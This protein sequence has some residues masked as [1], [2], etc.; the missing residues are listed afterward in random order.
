MLGR[1][2]LASGLVL[3]VFV[4]GHFL[5]HSLG[6]VSLSAMNQG[7]YYTIAPWR[8]A[9][10]TVIF[11]SALLTHVG[12]AVWALYSR[13]TLRLKPAEYVQAGLGF[14]IP[15]LIASHVLA[16]RGG[17]EAFGLEEGYALVLYAQWV[18]A[19]MRGIMTTSA[20]LVVWVHSCIGWHYWLRLKPWYQKIR[21]YAF[22]LALM[23]PILALSGLVSAGFRILRLSRSEKWTARV[24]K[25]IEGIYDEF[26]TFTETF[27]TYIHTGVFS[28]IGF[29]LLVHIVR[30]AIASL[31]GGETLRYRDLQLAQNREIK[32][33][34][35]ASVL[36]LLRQADIPHASVCGG[37]GRC[38]TCR[39]RVDDGLAALVP[40]G[41][42]ELRVLE[43][44][45]APPNVRL[46]CQMRPNTSLS[47]T[48]LLH[49]QAEV[50]EGLPRPRSQEGQ[51]Q[52]IAVLFADIRAF[53]KLSETQL[54]YDTA[55]LLNRYF[56]AMGQAIEGA[57]DT[58]TS[59]SVTV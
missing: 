46:A 5:N 32:L 36:D 8:T 58:W 39:V 47:I 10:G 12:L 22:S 55:F 25:N 9:P 7:W 29:V 3:F 1:L 43:R 18:D 31:P 6:I 28:I 33:Q 23:V 27:E 37:R 26:R 45:G 17:H 35:G 48:A 53:T 15:I 13:R 38:S 16:T 42:E 24:L 30:W 2:R 49:P 56:A 14:L 54:P 21:I 57:G 11:L 44:V 52:D 51:E 4:L 50:R 41:A 20:L 34:K 59:L 19:P 40:A